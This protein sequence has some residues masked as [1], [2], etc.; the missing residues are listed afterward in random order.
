MQGETKSG[1]KYEIDDRVLK[2]WRFVEAI[3]EADKG[4]GVAQLE[5]ARKMIHLMFGEDYDRF[6]EH[7]ANQND[8]FVPAEAVIAEVKEI[9]ENSTPKN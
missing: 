1:Y 7:I 2:D 6:M 5:G 9:F 3:T 4:K 8:G